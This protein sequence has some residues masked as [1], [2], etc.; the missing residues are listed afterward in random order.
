MEESETNARRT[1]PYEPP[2]PAESSESRRGPEST[3]IYRAARGILLGAAGFGIYFGAIHAVAAV[4]SSIS[5]GDASWKLASISAFALAASVYFCW[6]GWS[7]RSNLLRRL[8]LSGSLTLISL[9]VASGVESF[10][11]MEVTRGFEPPFLSILAFGTPV[12]LT[13]AAILRS[14]LK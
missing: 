4:D 10:V 5:T 6:D 2:Q 11:G 7:L 3:L 1:N 13:L 8:I 9:V 12:F 14:L